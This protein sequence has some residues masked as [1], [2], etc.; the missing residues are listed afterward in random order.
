MLFDVVWA[1]VYN[2]GRGGYGRDNEDIL[3]GIHLDIFLFSHG[4]NCET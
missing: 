3:R 2:I 1:L 4:G